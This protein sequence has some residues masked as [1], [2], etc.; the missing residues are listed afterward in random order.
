MLN[1]EEPLFLFSFLTWGEV[2]CSLLTT[3]GKEG[4][5]ELVF[6]CKIRRG[7][8]KEEREREVN[9]CVCVGGR[10]VVRRERGEEGRERKERWG[11]EGG[12]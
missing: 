1:L 8:G 11:R 7:G 9:K 6:T 5:G 4:T 3:A 10:G 2:N 12:G